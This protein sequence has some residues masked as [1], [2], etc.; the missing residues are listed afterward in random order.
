MYAAL[1]PVKIPRL[2]VS[3]VLVEHERLILGQDTDRIDA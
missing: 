1:K 2:S 3:Y